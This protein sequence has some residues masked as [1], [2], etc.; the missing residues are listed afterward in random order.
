[1][2]GYSFHASQR[3]VVHSSSPLFRLSLAYAKQAYDAVVIVSAKYHVLEPGD[4]IEYCNLELE[5]LSDTQRQVW[6]EMVM[7]KLVSKFHLGPSDKV[8][9]HAGKVYGDLLIR[10][11]RRTRATCVVPLRGK[12]I[13]ERMGWYKEHLAVSEH[14]SR[15]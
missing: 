7:S 8:L 10:R 9:F 5:N 6:S 1:M 11:L 12:R 15:G 13:G 2:H 14:D 4:I 3:E